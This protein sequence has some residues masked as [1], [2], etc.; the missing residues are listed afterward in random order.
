MSM[1]LTLQNDQFRRARGGYARM[2]EIAC[3][4]CKK[5]LCYYQ[6]DGP[7]IIKRMYIDRISHAAIDLDKKALH[8]NCGRI[9]GTRYIYKKEGREAFRIFVGAISKSLVKIT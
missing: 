2:L 7:G 5:R 4:K 1:K 6:K 3:T 8:C 9:I